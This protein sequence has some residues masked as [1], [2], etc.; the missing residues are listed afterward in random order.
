MNNGVKTLVSL[1]SIVI[2]SGCA[3]LDADDAI[4]RANR[5]LVPFT[6]GELKLH[7][8]GV[9]TQI[10]REAR[11][12]ILAAPINQESAVRLALIGSPALQMLLARKHADLID[13]QRAGRIGNPSLTYERLRDHGET[14]IARV[15]SV[16]LFELLTLPRRK[17]IAAADARVEE[18]R[19]AVVIVDQVTQIR[20]AWV[21]A[22]AAEQRQRYAE[23][24]LKSGSLSAELARR[25]EAVGNF[26]RI[27]RARQ[28]SFEAD[29]RVQA[30]VARQQ[31]IVE[32]EALVRLLGLTDDEVQRFRLPDRLPEIPKSAIDSLSLSKRANRERL[33]V[34]LADASYRAAAR[35]AGLGEVT[36]RTD[37][38][39]SVL[40]DGGARGYEVEVRLPVFD[41]GELERKALK[42]RTLSAAHEL[43]ATLRAAGSHLRESYSTYL[44]AHAVARSYLDEVV[45]LRRTISEENL[46][47]YNGMLIGVFELL[48]DAREQIGAVKSAIDAQQ[49]FWLAD[50]ALQSALVGQPSATTLRTPSS[51]A[52][53]AGADH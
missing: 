7:D 17:K 10:R 34:A 12:A 41:W 23:Q 11:E 18:L 2:C 37:L 26:N 8:T 30:Q 42:G 49:Q 15:L 13:A 48:T 46:L 25:M 31:A 51:G 1:F 6:Q 24:I 50:A 39:L 38:E 33:D 14:E 45:P 16:G 19:L 28:Q 47:R 9:L 52:V 53:S 32:R 35:R 40:R 3:S 29:A 5:T 27:E 21:R 20:Q 36:T 44:A 22:V 43:E 4:N